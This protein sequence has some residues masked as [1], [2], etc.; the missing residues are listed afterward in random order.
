M[1][2]IG[3]NDKSLSAKYQFLTDSINDYPLEQ[4]GFRFD[5]KGG[6]NGNPA[7]F[8][9]GI[10]KQSETKNLT[11]PLLNLNSKF[12]PD[13]KYFPPG[14]YSDFAET[15]KVSVTLGPLSRPG[16]TPSADEILTLG[17]GETIDPNAVDHFNN[18]RAT[19]QVLNTTLTVTIEPPKGAKSLQF[20]TL[21]CQIK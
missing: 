14:P 12:F 8:L 17:T 18:A 15:L 10:Y 3:P 2:S 4:L 13:L 21:D 20:I 19:S 9:C 5:A 6:C 1:V 16:A 7:S 11:L